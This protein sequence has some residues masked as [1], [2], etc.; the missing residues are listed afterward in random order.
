MW[1][2]VR[3]L[4]S[5]KATANGDTRDITRNFA[6]IDHRDHD[7]VEGFLTITGGKLTTARLMAEKTVDVVCRAAG[8]YQPLHDGRGEPLPGSEDHRTLHVSDRLARR[9]ENAPLPAG[10]LRV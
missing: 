1:A 6:L 8:E 2:G 9:E 5:A 4:Y 3:P 7:S 10:D